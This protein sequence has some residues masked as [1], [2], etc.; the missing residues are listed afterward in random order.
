[1]KD[2]VLDQPHE[3]GKIAA[4]VNHDFN[5]LF[6]GIDYIVQRNIIGPHSIDTPDFSKNR[7]G[8]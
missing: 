7:F 5:I 8:F 1:M 2:K 4:V 6:I 3:N